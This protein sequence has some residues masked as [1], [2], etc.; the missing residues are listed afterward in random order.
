MKRSKKKNQTK[1]ANVIKKIIT[2]LYYIHI[3]HIKH[4]NQ[5][6]K[7]T[8]RHFVWYKCSKLLLHISFSFSSYKILYVRI[9]AYGIWHIHLCACLTWQYTLVKCLKYRVI[10]NNEKMYSIDQWL[11]LSKLVNHWQLIKISEVGEYESARNKNDDLL[12]TAIAFS[13]H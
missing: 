4:I 3:H 8:A 7:K 9:N 6:L 5:V 1:H 2:Y 11:F 10:H 12:I 13:F